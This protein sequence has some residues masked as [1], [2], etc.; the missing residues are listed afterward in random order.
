MNKKKHSG[1]FL[2]LFLHFSFVRN[3]ERSLDIKPGNFTDSELEAV[4]NKK[5]PT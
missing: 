2:L 5:T 1:I 4:K 3:G